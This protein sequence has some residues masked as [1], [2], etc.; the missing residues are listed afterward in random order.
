MNVSKYLSVLSLAVL[1]SCGSAQLASPTESDVAK[2]DFGSKQFAIAD[3][4]AGYELYQAKCGLCHGLKDPMRYTE[5]Q[6]NIL[7]PGMVRK[8]NDKKN[9]QITSEQENQILAYVLTMGPYSK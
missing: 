3:V 7:V 8:A 2:A 1:A 9:T 6:W 5:E 4:N